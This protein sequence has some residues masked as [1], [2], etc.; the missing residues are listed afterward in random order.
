MRCFPKIKV[1]AAAYGTAKKAINVTAVVQNIVDNGVD[2][3]V[4]NSSNMSDDPVP[5]VIKHFG[6]IYCIGE[7]EE[8]VACQEGERVHFI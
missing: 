2:S 7:R 5:G 8:S 3:L 1:I 6:M 4:I